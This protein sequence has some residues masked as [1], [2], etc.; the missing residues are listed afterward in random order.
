MFKWAMAEG[1]IPDDPTL[2]VTRMKAKTTGYKTWS[3]DH[4]ARLEAKH[5]I[6]S[7][8]RL[9]FALILYTGLRRTD[10]AKIGRQHIHDGVLSIDQ[11]KTWS[12]YFRTTF[13]DDLSQC[14]R[15]ECGNRAGVL[16]RRH[17]K[18]I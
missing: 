15:D 1:R 7:K 13:S 16:K 12:T 3:E 18:G 17:H 4:I 8:E 11:G 9:A 6:G 10:V 2:G 14:D 5:P